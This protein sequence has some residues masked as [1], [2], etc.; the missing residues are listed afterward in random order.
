MSALQRETTHFGPMRGL[1]AVV[2]GCKRRLSRALRDANAR[3]EL[4]REFDHLEEAGA[5]DSVL[6][7]AGLSR[8]EIPTIVE[9]HPGAGKRLAGMLTRL[10]L[11][12]AAEARHGVE[13]Q[14]IQR[15]CLLCRASARCERWLHGSSEDDP[16]RFC[17]NV[18]AFDRLEAAKHQRS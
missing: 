2:M 8:A 13:M 10:G 5:L 16:R 6:G 14:D 1:L 12:S 9:N 7:D 17:P 18:E 15:T 3:A 4:K 11:R